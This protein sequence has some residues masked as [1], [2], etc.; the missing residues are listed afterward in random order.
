MHDRRAFVKGMA[1]TTGA[2]ATAHC[3]GGGGSS[4]TAPLA[5]PTAQARQLTTPLMGVGETVALFDGD[6]SIAVTR[7]GTSAVVAVSR[8]CTH[9]GCTVLLPE[10]P[11]ATLDCPCHGS[12]FTTQGQ[13]IN[14]PAV[15]PLPA[16]PARIDGATVVVSVG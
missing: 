2:L 16:Y 12:R 15:R 1:L 3:G 11:G 4:P 7:T 8:T 9:Q 14:G 5:P 6:Q 10:S 13:V